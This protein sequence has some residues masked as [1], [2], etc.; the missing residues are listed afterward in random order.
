MKPI[1][2]LGHTE[3]MIRVGTGFVLLAVSGFSV[4]PGWG[5]FIL[6]AI[7]IIALGTG[8]T[9]Y[10]PAWQLFGIQSCPTN[11]SSRMKSE[12]RKH[13]HPDSQ[14]GKP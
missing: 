9:G 10:C 6:M 7:G 11:P 13:E 12:T 14:T 3:R 8:I 2:N 1:K 5:D 4:F